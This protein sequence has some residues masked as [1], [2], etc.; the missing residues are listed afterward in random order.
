MSA[1]DLPSVPWCYIC[2]T[3]NKR[4]IHW[5]MCC[6]KL[7]TQKQIIKYEKIPSKLLERYK[8]S[9]LYT[10]FGYCKQHNIPTPILQIILTYYDFLK[11][12]KLSDDYCYDTGLQFK[13][14]NTVYKCNNSWGT[15]VFGEDIRKTK[16]FNVFNI[17]IKWKQINCHFV[18]GFIFTSMNAATSNEH[19]G[20]KANS[21]HS[22]GIRVDQGRHFTLFGSNHFLRRFD[23]K[24]K[25]LTFIPSKQF[26]SNDTFG[27]TFNL[28]TNKLTIQY[29]GRNINNDHIDLSVAKI[30][31]PAFSL[32]YKH[33][34]IEIVSYR[35][36]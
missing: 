35:Y 2:K 14:N 28:Q 24:K 21:A 17:Q 3:C 5:I 27:L 23:N 20:Q 9:S 1:D 25:K 26:D 4:G 12:R 10:V 18:M 19:L 15:F 36:T 22:V 13:S 31:I 29:N 34:A 7:D 11:F 30:I 32:Y 33:S 8:V 16:S 6:D